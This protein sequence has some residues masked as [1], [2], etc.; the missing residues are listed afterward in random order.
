MTRYL[1]I[2]SYDGYAYG[3][4]QKQIN[5][6]SIQEEIE[7]VLASIH[8]HPVDITASGR[9]D[10]G[11]HALGQAFHFD[12]E[13][14]L[15]DFHWTRAMNSL[16]PKDIRIQ[17][18]TQVHDEFHARFDA[19]KKRYDYL[20]TN[21]IKNP[22]YE[23]YMGKEWKELDVSRMKT[24]AKVLIGE[25]D[26]TSFTSNKI[27][28]RKPRVKTIT[29]LDIIEETDHIRMIFEGNGF[30][31]YMVR[32]IAQTLIEAGKH[33]LDEKD[34]RVMLEAKDKHS[35]RFKAQPQGLY[36]VKVYYE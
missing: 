24:C 3:G 20:V 8:G 1:A 21:D 15:D 5:T 29:R 7:K 9:T 17:H 31:R 27:D 19:V 10:A 2:V 28:P 11:V 25:H 4:W 34:V 6:I 35:C 32:M 12:S 18:V 16:L 23:R 22:F 33:R 26:F 14:E 13:R 36:L 30:L